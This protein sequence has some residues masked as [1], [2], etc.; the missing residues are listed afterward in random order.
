MYI[1]LGDLGLF[2]LFIII[3]IAGVYLIVVLRQVFGIFNRVRGIL[4]AHGDDIRKTL[5]VLPEALTNI[6]ELAI[7]LKET[8]DQTN[9]AFGSLQNNLIDTADDLRDGL[10]TFTIYAKAIRD[11]IRAIFSKYV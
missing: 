1:S 5:L 7:S 2:L 11:V 6:N 9:N 4:D 3:V 10:E 8:A